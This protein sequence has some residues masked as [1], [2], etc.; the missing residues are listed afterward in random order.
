MAISMNLILFIKRIARYSIFMLPLLSGCAMLQQSEKKTT[1]NLPPEKLDTILQQQRIIIANLNQQPEKVAQQTQ[2]IERLAAKISKLEKH[3]ANLIAPNQSE[4]IVDT[5]P[6]QESSTSGR[7]VLGQEEWVWFADVQASLTAR[8]DTGATTSSVSAKNITR[9]ERD[10]KNW[11]SFNLL[12]NKK[13]SISLETQIVRNIQVT[14]SSSM[15]PKRRVV[16]SLP[17]EIG[18]IKTS[19]EFTLTD[20]SHMTYPVL[21]GRSFLQDMA[22]VDVA[23]TYT[24]TKKAVSES[25]VDEV[26]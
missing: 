13:E 24:Q 8:V 3:S 20:R 16:V 25:A 1:V 21:L 4:E 26:K 17:I 15:K 19:S 2:I 12:F 7:M 6:E 11:V 10:G 22:L 5:T 18:A 9:F 23:K 14:Q